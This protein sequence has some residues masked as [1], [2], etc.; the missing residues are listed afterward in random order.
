MRCLKEI[1]V[2]DVVNACESA[3]RAKSKERRAKS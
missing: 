3:L 2:E 1:T